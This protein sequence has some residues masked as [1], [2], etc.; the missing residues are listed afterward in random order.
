MP[1]P[2]SIVLR[3]L[4]DPA[5]DL[6]AIAGRQLLRTVGHPQLGARTPIEQPHQVAG[7]GI[8][9]DH[10]RTELGSLHHALIGREIE[11]AG[12]VSLAAGLMALDASAFED[13]KYVL[14]EARRGCG[15]L[16]GSLC[17]LAGGIG[18]QQGESAACKRKRGDSQQQ[19]SHGT[20]LSSRNGLVFTLRIPCLRTGTDRWRELGDAG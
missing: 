18:N 17:P 8:A 14:T 9:W 5:P 4:P 7:V 16:R 20:L 11:P 3:S 2:Q 19:R 15:A 13:R 10:H 1:G 12:L 6:V